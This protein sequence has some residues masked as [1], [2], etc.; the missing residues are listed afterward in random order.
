MINYIL[1]VSHIFVGALIIAISIPLVR[2]SISMNDWYGV[3]FKKSFSSDENWY[4]INKYGRKQLIFWSSF[5]ILF[6]ALTL[7]M[8]LQGNTSLAIANSC[9]PLLFLITP[10]LKSYRYAKD[11]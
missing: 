11:L 4:K 5:L 2:G 8:P 10:V 1:A 6:G 7:F 3:R 9:A